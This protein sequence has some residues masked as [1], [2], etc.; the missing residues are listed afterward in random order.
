L[1][2]AALRA[3][4]S[5]ASFDS[6]QDIYRSSL[7][8]ASANVDL[9]LP[10]WRQPLGDSVGPS[11]GV[12]MVRQRDMLGI[13]STSYGFAYGGAA[14]VSAR[15]YAR[16]Y[17]SL[18]LDGG[19]ESSAWT[20]GACTVRRAA[21]CWAARWLSSRRFAARRLTPSGGFRGGVYKSSAPRVQSARRF[22]AS[23][24]FS[25]GGCVSGFPSHAIGL[26]GVARNTQRADIE[27]QEEPA[28]LPGPKWRF[29]ISIIFRGFVAPCYQPRE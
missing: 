20:A 16:T 29:W 18:N 23:A 17:L 21:P 12:P 3:R 13:V 6:Q 26:F 24:Y 1:R 19:G 10:L 22:G 15:V 2:W 11:L 7:L 5:A 4:I 25:D 9:L 8:R 28:Y 27:R 14:V